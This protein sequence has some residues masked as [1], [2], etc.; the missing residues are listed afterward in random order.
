MFNHYALPILQNTAHSTK[1]ILKWRIFG[2]PESE[3]A[4]LL[5]DALATIDCHTGYRWES[6][7]IEF[8]VRCRPELSEQIKNIVAPIVTPHII[9][10]V[11]KRA[12][13][14]LRELINS[15][16]EPITIIDEATGGLLQTTLT[17]PGLHQLLNF[18]GLK[19]NKLSFHAFGLD[20]YWHQKVI[21]GTTQLTLHYSNGLQAGTEIHTLPYRT[22]AVLEHATEWLSFRL[23]HLINQLHQ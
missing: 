9:S 12:S 13:D 3:I 16:N 15:L 6:P 19:K 8:K 20:E 7:Y 22:P 1:Q 23:I 18:N 21:H 4:Q 5:E 10:P 11:D 2:L 14:L 17:K